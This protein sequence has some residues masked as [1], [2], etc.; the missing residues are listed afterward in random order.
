MFIDQNCKIDAK[1]EFGNLIGYIFRFLKVF[2]KIWLLAIMY[3]KI[4]NLWRILGVRMIQ[5]EE[6]PP[7][8]PPPIPP[9]ENVFG[10]LKQRVYNDNW[11]A[12]NRAQLE[13]RFKRCVKK[14]QQTLILKLPMRE[15]M[16]SKMS[17]IDLLL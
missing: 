4:C 9:I 10:I 16:D 1:Y 3:Q 14:I 2:T 8:A 7:N 13:D 6:N 11:K 5:K 15:S 17:I 12:E